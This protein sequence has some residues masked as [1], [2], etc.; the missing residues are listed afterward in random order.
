MTLNFF[1]HFFRAAAFISSCISEATQV[2]VHLQRSRYTFLKSQHMYCDGRD[3]HHL[4]PQYVHCH[5]RDDRAWINKWAIKHKVIL[6]AS[7]RETPRLVHMLVTSCRC[8]RPV[9]V[10]VTKH[11]VGFY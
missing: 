7:E 10:V 2:K 8:Q 3:W 4:S 6:V 11:F 9:G 5:Y 1:L